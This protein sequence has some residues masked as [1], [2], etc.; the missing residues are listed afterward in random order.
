MVI[1]NIKA[2]F[3]IQQMAFMLLAVVLFF[4]LVGLFWVVLQSRNLQQ[5]ASS[6][7]EEQAIW[8]AEFLSGSSEFSCSRDLGSYCVDTDK[9]IILKNQEEYDD[10][11]PVSYV[12]V[13]KIDGLPEKSCNIAN[14]PDCNIFNVYSGDEVETGGEVGSFVALCRY[15]KYGDYPIK[16]CELGK[17]SIGT[18]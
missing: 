12:K 9:I 10:F 4:I 17:I 14:Y 1:K 7:E 15:E 11:W 8:L 18:G 5:Q 16:V 3:K 6:L 2:Q 13:R